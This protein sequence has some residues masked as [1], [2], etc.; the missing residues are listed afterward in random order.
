MEPKKGRIK[1]TGNL[2]MEFSFKPDDATSTGA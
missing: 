2:P 1:F